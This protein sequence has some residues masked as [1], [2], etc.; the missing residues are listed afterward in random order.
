MQRMM[1]AMVVA[2][3][4]EVSLIHIKM[5]YWAGLVMVDQPIFHLSVA[6]ATRME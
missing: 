5:V 3:M 1:V 6:L 2:V 4:K